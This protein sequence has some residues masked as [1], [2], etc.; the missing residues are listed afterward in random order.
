[1]TVWGASVSGKISLSAGGGAA[2]TLT[3]QLSTLAIKNFPTGIIGG[4]EMPASLGQQG[5]FL[6]VISQRREEM[7]KQEESDAK[8]PRTAK[9]VSGRG[10]G[11]AER[12]LQEA[13]EASSSPQAA[14]GQ[15]L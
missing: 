2:V 8:F 3:F 5:P 12:A 11:R 1:M 15:L 9:D 14:M 13:Q 4:S 6:Q 7:E 10:R